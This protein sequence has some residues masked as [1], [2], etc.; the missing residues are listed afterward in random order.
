MRGY[1]RREAL[2]GLAVAA[3]AADTAKA[4]NYIDAHVHVWTPDTVSF[5]HDKLRNGR[6]VPPVSFTPEQLLTLARPS[7]LLLGVSI[8]DGDRVGLE[9]DKTADLHPAPVS[10]QS[11]SARSEP[12]SS[13]LLTP[14]RAQYHKFAVVGSMAFC[15]AKAQ[16]GSLAFCVQRP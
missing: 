1:T 8:S 12:A 10:N 14:L 4:S 6:P 7:G 9:G 2:A 16:G 3:R 5:P 11:T 13:T 15:G